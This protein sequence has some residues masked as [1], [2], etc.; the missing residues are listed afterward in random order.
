[1]K[2]WVGKIKENA[3]DGL[4]KLAGMKLIIAS[5]L[6]AG[7]EG[8][9]LIFS[10]IT[11]NDF[12]KYYEHQFETFGK[13]WISEDYKF[14]LNYVLD[15]D[16]EIINSTNINNFIDLVSLSK[17]VSLYKEVGEMANKSLLEFKKKYSL[18]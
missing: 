15:E 10:P 4:D 1:M 16:C 13:E 9:V 3:T 7:K 17:E 18:D 5:E 11:L 2:I 12:E 8:E 14:F 6:Y